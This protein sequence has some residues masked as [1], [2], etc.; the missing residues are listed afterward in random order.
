MKKHPSNAVLLLIALKIEP[1]AQNRFDQQVVRRGA[2]N[3]ARGAVVVPESVGPL[4]A[5]LDRLP[6]SEL[7][8]VTGDLPLPLEGTRFESAPIVNAPRSIAAAVARLASQ[9]YCENR[10]ADPAALDANYVRRS[11]AELFWREI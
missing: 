5:W 1:V 10:A 2:V 3:D 4:A 11:D 7:G 9:A 8:F 6:D